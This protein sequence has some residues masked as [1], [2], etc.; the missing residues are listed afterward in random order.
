MQHCSKNENKCLTVSRS[1]GAK[2]KKKI[3]LSLPHSLLSLSL[4]PAS[5]SA[6]DALRD[7]FSG[8]LGSNQ[9]EYCR[10]EFPQVRKRRIGS[11]KRSIDGDDDDDD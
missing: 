10:K 6:M 5:H 3:T 1:R 7:W 2:R 4:F 9:S 8:L 11:S